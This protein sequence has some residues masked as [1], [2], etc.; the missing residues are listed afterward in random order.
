[1]INNVG[2]IKKNAQVQM[3]NLKIENYRTQA[4]QD[5]QQDV[6]LQPRPVSSRNRGIYSSYVNLSRENSVDSGSSW[7]NKGQKTVGGTCKKTTQELINELTA[8]IGSTFSLINNG[9]LKK[10]NNN[11]NVGNYKLGGGSANQ[12]KLLNTGSNKKETNTNN[13]SNDLPQISRNNEQFDRPTYFSRA[14]PI[15]PTG[16]MYDTNKTIDKMGYL[17]RI[18]N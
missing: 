8:D 15:S 4:V 6:Y 10:K 12:Q 16:S 13:F 3:P 9:G 17:E 11:K 5:K 18:A 7:K 14:K 1:M 2:E